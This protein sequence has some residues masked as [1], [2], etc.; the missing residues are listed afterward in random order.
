M[1]KTCARCGSLAGR[2]RELP[3]PGDWL[4]YLRSERDLSAPV[5]RLA[6][7]LCPD[8]A[9][10][11]DPLLDADADSLDDRNAFLDELTLD[12]LIDEGA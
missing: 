5:G 10:E 2:G 8:C 9:R 3:V 11:A 1:P 4:S 12:A 7:P 6:M